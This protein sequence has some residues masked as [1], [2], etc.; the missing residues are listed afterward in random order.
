VRDSKKKQQQRI[1]GLLRAIAE[2]ALEMSEAERERYLKHEKREAYN[3]AIKTG[4][5][6]EAATDVSERMDEWA[7]A[8]IRMIQAGRGAA[9]GRRA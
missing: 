9:G 2:E 3:D 7:R 1:M 8:L 4:M 5:T 6:T